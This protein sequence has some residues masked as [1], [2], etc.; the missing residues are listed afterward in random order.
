MMGEKKGNRKLGIGGYWQEYFE[1]SGP[2]F[3]TDLKNIKSQKEYQLIK[4]P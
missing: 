4:I 3:E 2:V 1:N